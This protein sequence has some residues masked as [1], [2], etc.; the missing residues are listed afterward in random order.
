MLGM[1]EFFLFG[2]PR[3]PYGPSFVRGLLSLF[4]DAEATQDQ[5]KVEMS[6]RKALITALFIVV[7]PMHTMAK[8]CHKNAFNAGK[9]GYAAQVCGHTEWMKA[10]IIQLWV[11]R[12]MKAPRCMTQANYK[13]TIDKW[14][15]GAAAF[16]NELELAGARLLARRRNLICSLKIT[17]CSGTV[18]S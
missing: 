9:F 5:A 1:R 17:K 3:A 7:A 13:N 6:R 18:N 2:N 11:S 15:D 14:L 16:K 10:D 4:F 12:S 8:E